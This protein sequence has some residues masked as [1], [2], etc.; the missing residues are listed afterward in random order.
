MPTWET[1]TRETIRLREGDLAY[2]RVGR[3]PDLVL[4]HGWPLHAATFRHLVPRLADRFTLHMIDLPGAGQS[5]WRAPLSLRASADA[6]A[7]ALRTLDLPSYAL[8]GHDS[9][10]AMARRVA[11]HDR[12]VRALVLEDTEI[13][14]S[15]TALLVALIAVCKLPAATRLYPWA[16]QM[17]AF[18]RSPFAFGSCFA[19]PAYVDTDFADLF[20]KPLADA[21]VAQ[22]QMALGASFDLAFI[23]E[24]EAVHP[25]LTMPTLCIW[26]ER[27]PFFPVADA[28]A[29]AATLPG[30]T[31]FVTIP[32]ARLLPHE[33]HAA[34]VAAAITAFL[35]RTHVDDALAQTAPRAMA[36]ATVSGRIAG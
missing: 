14:R 4:V 33:D 6:L 7:E 15:K 12:R 11:A 27:D 3:G 35:D 32:G 34:E 26:G 16:L 30:P 24:L 9:G 1:A 20:V 25:R 8:F 31:T 10:G 17:R 5:A 29:M 22:A 21:R 13:P 23:N 2:Y 36:C 18:R 28:R 19:D